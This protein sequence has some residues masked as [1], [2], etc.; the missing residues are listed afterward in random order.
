MR[1]SDALRG[2]LIY[3][4]GD[5]AAAAIGDGF[6]W[7][8]L[9]GMAAIGA[10]LYALEIPAWFRWIDRREPRA[11]TAAAWRRAGWALLYFNPIWIARH[12]FFIRLFG[13]RFEEL[14]WR[15]LVTG[16]I[17]FAVNLPAGLA[18][19]WLIQNRVPASWR[20]AASALYSAL[21]AAYYAWS[22]TWFR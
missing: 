6:A 13:G 22:G 20:F 1:R 14:G 4:A 8:R 7:P 3:G 10:T 19:N 5:A 9:A 18:A 21:M 16:S 2:L 15:L 11:G 12:L 17:S